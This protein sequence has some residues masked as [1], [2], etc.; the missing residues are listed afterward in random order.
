[1]ESL[2]SDILAGDMKIANLFYSVKGGISVRNVAKEL[3][4]TH[5]LVRGLAKL[6]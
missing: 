1:M 4:Q 2:V 5:I 3:P 6:L